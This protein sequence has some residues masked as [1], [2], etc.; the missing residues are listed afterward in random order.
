MG[1]LW[2]GMLTMEVWSDI[3]ITNKKLVY[4]GLDG[5]SIERKSPTKWV[6]WLSG[7]AVLITP[8]TWLYWTKEK[9]VECSTSLMLDSMEKIPYTKK[10]SEFNDIN[11]SGHGAAYW[12]N[13]TFVFIV[14]KIMMDT[15]HPLLNHGMNY[16]LN[17]EDCRQFSMMS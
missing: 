12:T 7:Y 17:K 10:F 15:K 16:T 11:K 6:F 8:N 2:L 3:Q 5:M 14:E 13:E 9:D 4:S 1:C